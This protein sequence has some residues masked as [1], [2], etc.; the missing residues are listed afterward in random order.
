[1]PIG[2]A[3]RDGDADGIPDMFLTFYTSMNY[4][5]TQSRRLSGWLQNGRI[6]FDEMQI[7]L[8]P[9]PAEEDPHCR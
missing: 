7:R 5:P 1:L 9:S 2:I 6:F 4:R 3:L 8:M